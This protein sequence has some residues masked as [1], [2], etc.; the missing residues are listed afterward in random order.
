MY[1]NKSSYGHD[2]LNRNNISSDLSGVVMDEFTYTAQDGCKITLAYDS[3][4]ND[5]DVVRD[6]KSLMESMVVKQVRNTKE[7]GR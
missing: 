4:V 6:I 5:A 1:K 2:E 3:S 7:A